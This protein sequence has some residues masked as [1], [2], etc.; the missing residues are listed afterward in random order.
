MSKSCKGS[1]GLKRIVAIKCHPREVGLKLSLP[2]LTWIPGS[3]HIR[4]HQSIPENGENS[5]R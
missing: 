1:G 3:C 5:M 2:S 4:R